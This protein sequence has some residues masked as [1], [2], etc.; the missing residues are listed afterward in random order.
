MD[1]AARGAQ[2]RDTAWMARVGPLA[3]PIA[4]LLLGLALLPW[5][6]TLS[7]PASDLLQRLWAPRE[8]PAGLLL[9]DIDDASLKQLQPELG[10]W[11]FARDVH[12]L[13]IDALRQAGARA[14]VLD[15]LL[16]DARPG[17]AALA[18]S[19]ARPGAP[20]LL[21]AAGLAPAAAA[22]DEPTRLDWTGLL[23]PSS[24]LWPEARLPALG[25]VTLP[26]DGDGRLRR[27]QL[28]HQAGELR[29]PAMPLALWRALQPPGSLATTPWPVDEQGRLPLR[30]PCCGARLPV[31]P[32]AELWHA[33]LG[34]ADARAADAAA[35]L[36][37]QVEGRVVFIGSSAVLVDRVMTVHG[38]RPGAEALALAYG[39]LRDGL[40]LRSPPP[41]LEAASMLLALLPGLALC[42]RR[43]PRLATQ[44][45]L[46]LAAHLAVLLAVLGLAVAL[47]GNVHGHLLG[48]PH[49]GSG[50]GIDLP[51]AAPLAMLVVSA[52][53]CGLWLHRR[54]QQLQAQLDRQRIAA[55]AASAAKSALLA[56]VSHEMRTPL[57]ALLGVA[58]LLA[59]APLQPLQRRQVGLLQQAG[60]TLATLID[61]LLDLSRVEA[62][63]L[64]LQPAP[65]ALRPLLQQLVEL[66]QARAAQKGLQ[67]ELDIADDVAEAVLVDAGRLRQALTNLIGNAI[68][69]TEQGR[70][71]LRV[72]PRP[73]S[74]D[75][76]PDLLDFEVSDTGIGIAASKLEAIFEPFV[77]A[78]DGSSRQYGGTGLGLAI[79]RAM[80]RQMGGDIRVSSQPGQG[81]RFTLSLPLPPA[82]LPTDAPVMP[83]PMPAPAAAQTAAPTV[84][85][86][87]VRLLLAE[88]NE[89]NVY[90]FTG[91]LDGQGLAIDVAANGLLALQMARERRYDLVFMDLQMPGMDGL[92]ATRE[93]RRWE[94]QTG[95]PRTPV[96]ALT[97]NAL[98]EDVQRSR[99]AG[100]DLHLGKPCSRAQLLDV[101][102]RLLPAPAGT[103]THTTMAAALAAQPTSAAPAPATAV[104]DPALALAR[105]GGDAALHQRVLAHSAVFMAHWVDDHDSADAERRLALVHDLKSIAR[106]VGA[107]ALGAAAERLERLLQPGAADERSAPARAAALAEVKAM[108]GPV[109]VA[110]TRPAAPP[111]SAG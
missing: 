72:T 40:W 14:V 94:A 66:L 13:A 103:G 32:F 10:P 106:T 84:S 67:L 59:A 9:V 79:C 69:F 55:E 95:R 90:V 63:M 81:S 27:L 18:R 50:A 104:L 57:N 4:V 96:V 101:I 87:G 48:K 5:R 23:A 44:L 88:D 28:W 86:T 75:G 45:G 77:Q 62:G 68:K 19:L 83:Q 26:L 21:A 80:A 93:L 74:G 16:A 3:I 43:W 71:A 51:L 99:E 29:L 8:A 53:L 11:P 78:S 47:H 33:A 61:E 100:C 64:Q 46:Q 58:E 34:G 73:A 97:A 31:L 54:A 49:N 2:G 82:E 12:A 39:A 105:L 108:L 7:Q 70:V 91:L 56:N 36:R 17:D 30:W 60:Q 85:P 92:Q 98:P 22:P 107:D 1:P 42:W 102:A 38:Q 89:V 25:M 65:C 24:T 35:A 111:P 41:A 110:L 6:A 52:L 76:A 37:H 15:V 109:V 20:V